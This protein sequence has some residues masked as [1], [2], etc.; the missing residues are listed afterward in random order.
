MRFAIINDIHNGPPTR[1]FANG[2]QRKLTYK[3]ESLV[4]EFIE[5]MNTTI[6]PEFVINLGDFIEDVN[7]RE[8]DLDYFKKTHDLFTSLKIPL[9]ALIGNHDV[10]TL[11]DKDM[12]D[13]LGYEKLY[14][15]FDHGDY[16]FICLSF[17]MTGNHRENLLDIKAEI[18]SDQL[19]WLI[20]D[21]E[22][23]NKPVIIFVHYG[24]ADDDMKGN[25]WFE[26]APNYA[27]L[28]N[29]KEVK[30][31][32]EKSGKVKTVISGHQHWNRMKVKN[33]IPYFVIT[34]LVENFKNDGV[35]AEAHTVVDLDEHGIVVDVKGNDPATFEYKFSK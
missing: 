22:T 13:I 25:F 20:Q 9:Y 16:H 28:E 17:T 3:A 12:L 30:D 34:S 31:I 8:T 33:G 2:V 14:Y 21:L 29:R 18:L 32:L 1:G 5:E 24:L 19:E 11:T 27:L 23:T 6:H 15:S 35:A 26:S 7:N 4:K 10:R